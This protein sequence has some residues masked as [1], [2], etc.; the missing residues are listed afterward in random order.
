MNKRKNKGDIQVYVEENYFRHVDQMERWRQE[1][2]HYQAVEKKLAEV[3]K[4]TFE[5]VDYTPFLVHVPWKDQP[6]PNFDYMLEEARLATESRF[7]IPIAVR[8][9][10]F[11]LFIFLLILSSKAYVLWITGTLASVTAAS[12]YLAFNERRNTIESV[13]TKTKAEIEYR[14]ELAIQENEQ[15]RHEHELKEEQ[16]IGFINDLLKSEVSAI[17]LRLDDVLSKMD[18]PF[19]LD[20]DIDIFENVPL[21]RVWLP[22]KTIIPGQTC[23]LLPSGRLSFEEKETS[24]INKQYLELCAAIIIRIVAKIYENIPGF[25]NGYALGLKK[26]SLQNEC[27][28]SIEINREKLEL[29]CQA[30][31]GLTA[32]Q[33]LGANFENDT[34]LN[35]RPIDPIV[36]DGWKDV[37][38]QMVRTLNVKI[39]KQ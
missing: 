11:I 33:K 30:Q 17:M 13:I 23:S 2:E 19:P 39:F 5:P 6:I 37:P 36:P 24:K 12:L 25:T 32:L 4:L 34:A 3:S 16:R 27:F 7:F 20:I 1:F 18:L 31:T 29:A 35:L 14:T 9:V 10:L 28:F 21:I 15:A 38:P 26:E 22:Q 8:V